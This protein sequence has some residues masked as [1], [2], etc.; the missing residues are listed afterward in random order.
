MKQLLPP[1]S[2]DSMRPNAS[3][4]TSMAPLVPI[5]KHYPVTLR[6]VQI[7]CLKTEYRKCIQTCSDLLRHPD[8]Q[9]HPIHKA[10]ILFYSALSH[11]EMGR[12]MHF[13]S[14]AKMPAL[15][16]AERS[17]I[18]ALEALP[19]PKEADLLCTALKQEAS[20]G[21]FLECDERSPSQNSYDMFE[22]VSLMSS[23]PRVR[24]ESFSVCSPIHSPR[25][26]TSELDDFDD[27]ESHDSFAELKTPSRVL[28]RESSR[29]S[30]L[31]ATPPAQRHSHHTSSYQEC[32][33][34]ARLQR[35]FSRMSLIETPPRKPMSQGLLRPIRPGS[36]PK[37]FYIPPR[38]ANTSKLPLARSRTHVLD[39]TP[40]SSPRISIIS[41]RDSFIE[42]QHSSEP[43]SP[44]SRLSSGRCLSDVSTI[45]AIS[46]LTPTRAHAASISSHVDVDDTLYL[47]FNDHLDSMR[48]QLETHITLVKQVRENL[49]EFLADRAS[50]KTDPT[51][52]TQ[53]QNS[54]EFSGI[55]TSQTGQQ[56]MRKTL[57]SSAGLPRV[58]SYWSFV[59]EDEK[60][61]EKLKRIRA[62]RERK[63]E[64][65]TERFDARR[66][67]D[68]CERALNELRNAALT[69]T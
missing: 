69:L 21:P 15:D 29:M 7:L 44:I 54:F 14:S 42:D 9:A 13:N 68:L 67:Q 41:A 30:L 37:P 35:D 4:V 19:T 48:M 24:R 36:P 40:V 52:D 32:P 11:D 60:V 20:I 57:V 64:R 62:G 65:K 6:H 53:P 3:T 50:S 25:A 59:P 12:A 18:A 47:R 46:P 23:P 27:L 28:G 61:A 8:I 34:P 58:R 5:T 16:D 51:I 56:A 33:G 26:T 38:L 1:D 63:W 17:Y 31:E 55:P 2:M 10:F 43:V 39:K 49:H 66:Y 45:S 22:K